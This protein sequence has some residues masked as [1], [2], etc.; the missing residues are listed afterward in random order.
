MLEAESAT[1]VRH[2][3]GTLNRMHPILE[4]AKSRADWPAVK[5]VAASLI[6]A[7]GTPGTEV[8]LAL[9]H[10]C[11]HLEDHGGADD[12]AARALAVDPAC[13][14]A[15]LVHTWVATAQGDGERALAC[16]RRLIELN[17]GVARWSLKRIQLLNW[18]GYVKEAVSELEAASQRWPSDPAIRTFMR[19]YGPAAKL[20]SAP[21]SAGQPAQPD[22]DHAEEQILGHVIARAPAPGLR[23]RPILVNNADRDVLTVGPRHAQTAVLVFT[24]SNDAI[25][26][27]LES[28][29]LYLATLPITVIYL[30]DFKRLRFLLGIES[31]SADYA[32]TV[33]GLRDLL[34]C[35][36]VQRLCAL[37]NCDGAFAAIR[38]GVELGAERILAFH[39]PTCCSSE[40]AA[41]FEQARN[42]KR[43]RLDTLVPHDMSDLKPFLTDRQY[44]AQMLLFYDEQ[45]VRDRAHALR[46]SGLPGV[47]LCPQPGS[48]NHRLLRQFALSQPDFRGQLADWLGVGLPAR[49]EHEK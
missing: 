49:G 7:E 2:S 28:F 9:A 42:F 36:G 30:K 39:A 6:E 41:K 43:T 31:L 25:S 19:N 13:T 5:Q 34:Q 21:T 17:P 11:W 46:L 22:P 37:G 23:L 10:A 15:V 4:S 26:M 27:P 35:L 29:D 47:N 44:N 1:T 33:A 16:Y 14:E 48:S 18:L 45:D 40:A 12:A 32:G 8:L 20:S 3:F 38:Y 24:G